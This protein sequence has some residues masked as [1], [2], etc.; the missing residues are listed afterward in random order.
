MFHQTGSGLSL[1]LA[2]DERCSQK[3]CSFMSGREITGC[4]SELTAFNSALLSQQTQGTFIT[5]TPLDS[6]TLSQSVS[7]GKILPLAQ[8]QAAD[9]SQGSAPE[10]C[11]S[12]LFLQLPERVRAQ[13]EASVGS[14]V[15]YNVLFSEMFPAFKSQTRE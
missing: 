2:Q 11:S 3:C 13:E 10:K 6:Q 4:T 8:V 9:G 12:L 1:L 7:C 15:L 14:S 5:A